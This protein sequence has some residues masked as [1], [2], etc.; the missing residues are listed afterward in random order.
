MKDSYENN[1]PNFLKHSCIC[2]LL[3]LVSWYFLWRILIHNQDCRK[4]VFNL[5]DRWLIVI[6]AII[7]E[8]YFS[9]NLHIHQLKPNPEPVHNRDVN[10]LPAALLCWVSWSQR[11]PCV[12]REQ[13][14]RNQSYVCR[15]VRWI[16][17]VSKNT[18]L[19]PPRFPPLSSPSTFRELPWPG[20]TSCGQSTCCAWF[21]PTRLLRYEHILVTGYWVKLAP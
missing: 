11:R 16:V 1:N 7:S 20:I 15:R 9:P 12:Q 6:R 13:L 21:I 3:V 2:F 19:P 8:H 17:N 10:S 5:M 4:Q 14:Y 18:P